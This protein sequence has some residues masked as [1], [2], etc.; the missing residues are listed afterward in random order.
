MPTPNTFP[1]DGCLHIAPSDGPF[2][3][4]MRFHQ[5]WYRHTVLAL[6]PGPN[7]AA[8]GALYGNILRPEDGRRGRNFLTETIHAVAQH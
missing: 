7:P 3:A 4:R 1:E 2:T 8:R 5:S 6:P